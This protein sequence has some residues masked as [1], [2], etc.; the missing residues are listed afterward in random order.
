MK[1]KTPTLPEVF[2]RYNRKYFG[3]KLRVSD[4]RFGNSRCLGE[5]AFFDN[6]PPIIVIDRKMM[7]YGRIVRMILLHEMAHV[8]MSDAVGVG[9]GPKFIRRMR[10]LVG[11]GAFD[12]LL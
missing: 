12:D 4:V 6:C 2:R 5:T 3:G 10:R 8:S 11:Q 1:R 7:N 9:H